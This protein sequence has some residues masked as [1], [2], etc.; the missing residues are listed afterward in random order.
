MPTLVA[1]E[2]R[3]MTLQKRKAAFLCER[4]R[5]DVRDQA[6]EVLQT[7][8]SLAK[9]D[10]ANEERRRR[11][12]EREGRR[13]RRRRTREQQAEISV[14]IAHRDGDSSDDEVPQT[15][16]AAYETTQGI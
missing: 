13:L 10:P 4:R 6:H 9:K 3:A 12:A 5:S 2:A 8:G 16:S 11:C 1:L 15:E 14:P 7:T